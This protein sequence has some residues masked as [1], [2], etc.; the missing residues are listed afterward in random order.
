MGTTLTSD[1]GAHA[2][3]LGPYTLLEKLPAYGMVQPYVGRADGAVEL[4]LVKRLLIELA[5]DRTAQQRFS[6]EAK[7]AH[8][9]R[10]PNVVLALD[11]GLDGEVFFLVTEWVR[12]VSLHAV[13]ARLRRVRADLPLDVF[14]TIALRVLDGLGYAHAATDASGLP[15]DIVHRDL[16]PK[17]LLLS[18]AGEVK[19]AD[20]G[21]AQ[22]RVDD[23][24]TL[25][26]T[27]VGSIPYMSPEQAQGRPLDRRSDLYTV[28]VV[29]Y[30][31]LAGQPAVPE[32]G[33]LEMLRRVVSEE[34]RPLAALRP[35]LPPP[36]VQAVSR[37]LAKDPEERWPDA[38]SFAR[39]LMPH[40]PLV[41]RSDQVLSA[42]VRRVLPERE[43]ETMALLAR[44]RDNAAA[45]AARS[46][47]GLNA[48]G[49]VVPAA[50]EED[51]PEREIATQVVRRRAAAEEEPPEP[52]VMTM[53]GAPVPDTTGEG[54]P[55]HVAVEAPPPV[56]A[57]ASLG[58]AVLAGLLAVALGVA[59]WWVSRDPAPTPPVRAATPAPAPPTET[60]AVE[61]K[62]VEKA[63]ARPRAVEP[64]PPPK[65]ARRPPRAPRAPAPEAP[66]PPR[67]GQATEP[68][69]PAEPP[70]APAQSRLRAQLAALKARP[71]DY[72]AFAKLHAALTRRA[73][74]LP[75]ARRQAVL[76]TLDAAERALDVEL[77]E[78]A[79]NKIERR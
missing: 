58:L 4:V 1:S 25:P 5:S 22:A 55:V 31:L 40:L 70:P 52:S 6:R 42:F 57:R 59:A 10:H 45:L 36:I 35:D 38:A 18:F 46:T 51:R 74:S 30:E 78:R 34:P 77:L 54:P 24:K 3:R 47:S 53:P 66:A 49:Q 9:L 28:G 29:F 76:A 79:L 32:A 61:P 17:S 11:H 60:V 8:A 15:L 27:A 62:P 71:R 37:A 63:V 73:E 56:R 67:S 44:I 21:V 69:P 41:P 20:F 64:P 14:A 43:A 13:Q 39:A 16:A 2:R 7:I 12:G 23:F 26:G 65:P 48:A 75:K 50:P 72:A 68:P 33:Q 19:I